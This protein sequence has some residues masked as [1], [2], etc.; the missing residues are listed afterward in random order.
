MADVFLPQN[1]HLAIRTI[2][3]PRDTN[4]GGDIF[5]GWLVSQMDL[6]AGIVASIKAEGRVVTVAIDG[7]T[8]HKPVFVGDEISCY[9]EIIKIG[10]TSITI[11]VEAWVRRKLTNNTMKVTEGIFTFV[12]I[13]DDHTPRVI[14]KN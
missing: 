7:L 5:G 14:Q 2:A 1:H 6:A 10:R 11:K 9:A 4:P 13:E 3:M 8:F 12:A